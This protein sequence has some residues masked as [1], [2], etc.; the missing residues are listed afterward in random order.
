[1]VSKHTHLWRA[2]LLGVIVIALFLTVRT[3]VVPDSYGAIGRYR[4]DAVKEEAAREPYLPTREQCGACHKQQYDAV[5]AGVH[6][7]V[8]CRHC[9]GLAKGHIEQCT[10]A[11]QKTPGV[12]VTEGKA[13]EN[14]LTKMDYQRCTH[15][16]EKRGGPPQDFPLIVISEH[17]IEMESDDPKDPAACAECHDNHDPG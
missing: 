2:G 7:L 17:L 5:R 10:Q 3:L 4:G 16:H 8:H 14:F 11:A 9:H 6:K 13:A 15:C 1:M 12:C